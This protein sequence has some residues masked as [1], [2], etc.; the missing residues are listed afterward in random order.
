M[1]AVAFGTDVVLPGPAMVGLIGAIAALGES[2]LEGYAIVGGVAVAARLGGAHRVTNDVD[3]V[4][5]EVA[6]PDAVEALLALP[7][8]EADPTGRHRVRVGGTKVE[9]IGVGPVDDN[10]FDGMTRIADAVRRC[11]YMGARHGNLAD[12]GRRSRPE[13]SLHE[14][15]RDS[16]RPRGHEAACHPGPPSDQSTR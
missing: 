14:P 11:P 12:I 5:D 2:G 10:S 6:H 9:F 7:S 16:R 3:T 8:A 15:V 13:H 1:P 4:V